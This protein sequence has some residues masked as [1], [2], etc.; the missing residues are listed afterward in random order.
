MA[1]LGHFVRAFVYSPFGHLARLPSL[2][3][4]PFP[5]PLYEWVASWWARILGGQRQ[6][7]YGVLLTR[8]PSFPTLAS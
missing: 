3:I 2:P 1:S 5:L 8:H 4:Y 7:T 6:G